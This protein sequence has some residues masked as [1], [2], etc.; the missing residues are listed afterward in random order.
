MSSI[1]ALS[2]KQVPIGAALPQRNRHAGA[3]E[4]PQGTA[5]EQP[6]RAWTQTDASMGFY[7]MNILT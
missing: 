5:D 3:V 1:I 2:M 4:H 7:M 6:L